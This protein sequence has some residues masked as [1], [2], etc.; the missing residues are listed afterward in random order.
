MRPPLSRDLGIDLGTANTVVYARNEGVI[1]REPSWIAR[2]TDSGEILAVGDEAKRMIGR[3]PANIVA[4]R[5]LRQGVIAD[6]ETT[7]AML[8]YFIRK[9]TTRRTLRRPVAVVGVPWG[10]TRVERKSFIEAVEQAGARQV[11]LVDQPLAAAIGAGLPVFEPVGS[12]VV[13]IGGGTTEIAVVALG[14]IVAA[15]SIPIAGD[16]MDAAIIQYCRQAYNLHIGERTAEEIK[17]ALGSAAPTADQ[18]KGEVRGRDVVS[19]MPRSVQI[20]DAELREALA[21]PVAAIV[22]AVRQT[23]ELVPPELAADL[24]VRGITLVG[25][26]ALLRG[27]DRVLAEETGMTVVVGSDPLSAVA[28]GTGKVLEELDLYRRVAPRTH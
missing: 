19:G 7:T 2:R 3:T 16:A 28:L 1:L 12:M 23:L 17:I 15:K 6:F 26:G 4:S 22:E 9:G 13:D 25:G 20:S 21:G 11:T 8:A 27:I 5:P 18:R 10:A 24:G 14:G